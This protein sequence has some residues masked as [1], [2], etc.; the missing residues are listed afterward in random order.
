[1]W[2]SVHP[3]NKRM[4]E[5]YR[6]GRV[7]LAGDAAH[8]GVFFGMQTGIQD[9]YNLGWKLAHVLLG[10]PDALLDTYQVERLPVARDDLAAGGVAV[11]AQAVANALLKGTALS[12]SRHH[13]PRVR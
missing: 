1:T 2:V 11:G 12:R 5:R 3:S 8:V 7:L 9:V 10:A 6:S 13:P 4:V